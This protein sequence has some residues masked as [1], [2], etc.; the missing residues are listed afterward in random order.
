MQSLQAGWGAATLKG[1]DFVVHHCPC[2][3]E[4]WLLLSSCC[5]NAKCPFYEC[6][7]R[8]FAHCQHQPPNTYHKNTHQH[9][10]LQVSLQFPH[11]QAHK[12]PLAYKTPCSPMVWKTVSW[13]M[14]CT[15]NLSCPVPCPP[16]EYNILFQTETL[17]LRLPK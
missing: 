6:A 7:K 9:N 4:A 10:K 14:C 3:M 17:M 2:L 12:P 11:N 15:Y 5:D 1:C 13:C 8:A 16:S